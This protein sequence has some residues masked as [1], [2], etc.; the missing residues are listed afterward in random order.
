VHL[1]PDD[2]P[3][4]AFLDTLTA[5][6]AGGHHPDMRAATRANEQT[7]MRCAGVDKVSHP[8]LSNTAQTLERSAIDNPL[9]ESREEY[10]CRG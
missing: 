7:G 8:E 1:L 9:L 6:N 2:L 3:D 5:N 10:G 4:A